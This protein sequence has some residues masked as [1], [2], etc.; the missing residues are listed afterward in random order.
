VYA[1][2]A[3]APAADTPRARGSGFPVAPVGGHAPIID[4]VSHVPA[5][6][7]RARCHVL[8]INRRRPAAAVDLHE[9]P[10]ICP[11]IMDICPRAQ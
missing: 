3:P 4:E 8:I 5:A 6:A 1:T 10:D 9:Q 7:Y 11:P 2:G